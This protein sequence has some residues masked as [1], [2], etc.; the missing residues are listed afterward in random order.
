MNTEYVQHLSKKLENTSLQNW[1][2]SLWQ[3]YSRWKKIVV[4]MEYYCTWERSG[5]IYSTYIMQR[6]NY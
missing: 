4:G 5:N 1:K 6:S 3:S 2:T